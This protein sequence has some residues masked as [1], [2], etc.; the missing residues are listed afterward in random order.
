MLPSQILSLHTGVKAM[1]VYQLP[2]LNQICFNNRSSHEALRSESEEADQ[3]K[4]RGMNV[5]FDRSYLQLD[6]AGQRID[7]HVV[8]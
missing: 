3:S 6:D 7:H 4:D 8:W 2:S 1:S 5:T